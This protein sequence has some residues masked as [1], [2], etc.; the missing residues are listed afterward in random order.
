MHALYQF[1]L[2]IFA[3][4]LLVL[5]C[6]IQS[7]PV[8]QAKHLPPALSESSESRVNGPTGSVSLRESTAWHPRE[9][10]VMYMQRTYGL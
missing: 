9:I 2:F 10:R 8:P 6:F 5:T 1:V 4:F 7:K 3:F